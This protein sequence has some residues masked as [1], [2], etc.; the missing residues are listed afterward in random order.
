MG[1]EELVWLRI[2]ADQ[3]QELVAALY[4][5]ARELFDEVASSDDPLV[6]ETTRIRLTRLVVTMK[7]LQEATNGKTNGKMR[8]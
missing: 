8:W 1:E 2:P 5:V 7:A 3:A 6:N 4:G